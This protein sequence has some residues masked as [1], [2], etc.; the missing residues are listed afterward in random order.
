M[1]SVKSYYSNNVVQNLVYV[2][3]LPQ[4]VA[5]PDTLKKAEFF[6]RFGRIIRVAVGTTPATGNQPPSYTAYVTYEKEFDALRAIQVQLT[7]ED[8]RLPSNI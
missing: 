6:G 5:D 3:G 4:R 8:T 7:C 1:R 2:V